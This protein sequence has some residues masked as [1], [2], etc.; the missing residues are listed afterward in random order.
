MRLEGCPTPATTGY[1]QL[2]QPDLR[3]LSA[4]SAEPLG[5]YKRLA[6][7]SGFSV[8]T[9]RHKFTELLNASILQRVA[10]RVTYSALNLQSIPVLAT[11]S[12]G[13]VPKV[14]KACDLH[15]YTRYRVRCLGST[16]GLFMRFAIPQG[17]EFQLIEFLDA[18]K[19]LDLVDEYAIP[20]VSAETVYANP[21]LTYYDIASDTWRVT[22]KAWASTLD[23][24][25][26]ELQRFASSHLKRLDLNDLKLIHYL[27]MDARKPQKTLSKELH[28]PEYD[29][30]RRLKFIFDNRIVSSFEVILGRKLFR[31]GPLALFHASCNIQTT[32]AIATGIRKLPF[33]SWLSPTNDGFLLFSGL[34]TSL[35]MEVGTAILQRSRNVTVTWID[36]DTSLRY[37][38]DETPYDE[39][40]GEWRTSRDFVIEEPISILK[41]TLV[42]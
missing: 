2:T 28:I 37:Y 29:V 12:V 11:V 20:H 9:F 15:P 27:T 13:N 4:I 30:S 33:Q 8:Q 34:P 31:I 22:I 18:L 36:Y 10:A 40:T 41:K 23:K 6:D 5:S 17:S 19:Q 39:K 42:K 24:H 25:M 14:E 21:D 7:L 26:D 38:F 3:V 32:R 1:L 16:N 35:F